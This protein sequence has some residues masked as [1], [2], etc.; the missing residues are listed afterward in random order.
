MAA[1]IHEG[2]HGWRY[3]GVTTGSAAGGDPGRPAAGNV[4]RVRRMAFHA[5]PARIRERAMG[6]DGG[7]GVFPRVTFRTSAFSCRS[8]SC[9]IRRGVAEKA[10]RP[11]RGHAPMALRETGEGGPPVGC[12]RPVVLP[13]T[14]PDA[15]RRSRGCGVGRVSG[16]GVTIGAVQLLVDPIGGIVNL[17]DPFRPVVRHAE[18]EAMAK[19]A[20]FLIRRP[21][22]DGHGGQPRGQRPGQDGEPS[23]AVIQRRTL[24]RR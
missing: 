11:S 12:D 1:V 7:P 6:A 20:P 21:R 9:S 5:K 14:L 24:H 13:V 8:I 3:A 19:K 16:V 2:P 17:E 10:W 4:L 23:A 15:L 18:F 22:G